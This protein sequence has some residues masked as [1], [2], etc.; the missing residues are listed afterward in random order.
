MY[1]YM[2]HSCT[3]IPHTAHT[4]HTYRHTH[5]HT[6]Y[7]LAR[8]HMCI[9]THTCA[10]ITHITGLEYTFV[11]SIRTLP[12]RRFAQDLTRLCPIKRYNRAQEAC[13][14]TLL[15]RSKHAKNT[16]GKVFAWVCSIQLYACFTNMFIVSFKSFGPVIIQVNSG[17]LACGLRGGCS[18]VG[19][20]TYM[21]ATPCLDQ[22]RTHRVHLRTHSSSF[23]GTNGHRTTVWQLCTSQIASNC[24]ERAPKSQK[25]ECAQA[26]FDVHTHFWPTICLLL[27]DF[28]CVYDTNQCCSTRSLN[29][30][31]ASPYKN[32]FKIAK[33]YLSKGTFPH[34]HIRFWPLCIGTTWNRALPADAQWPKTLFRYVRV[35]THTW[36]CRHK[37]CAKRFLCPFV[38]VHGSL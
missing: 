12:V 10:H 2:Y 30:I 18:K 24:H 5:T 4:H 25:K 14:N 7:T 13:E 27:P 32:I 34:S 37:A 6:T 8:M 35:G 28:L 16:F 36:S 17:E 15:K 22:N 9:R 19:V 38:C 21:G 1:M 20:I 26:H 3:H 31:G 29:R 23:N 11:W 33:T